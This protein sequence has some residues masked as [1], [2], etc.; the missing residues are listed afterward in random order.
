MARGAPG[1]SDLPAEV[2]R[3]AVA[4]CL[5]PIG[6]ARLRAA[7]IYWR[8]VAD[9]SALAAC[10][11]AIGLPA[12]L[13]PAAVKRWSEQDDD[14][15]GDGDE[16]GDPSED[17]PSPQGPSAGWSLLPGTRRCASTSASA[18]AR[19]AVGCYSWLRQRPASVR[20]PFAARDYRGSS[21]LSSRGAEACDGC[22]PHGLINVGADPRCPASVGPPTRCEPPMGTNCSSGEM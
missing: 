16:D 19:S 22:A 12:G 17:E 8:A 18:L 5:D 9:A 2:Q 20:A 6:L 13:V 15:D 11:D 4:C 14:N 3:S 21:R 10:A 7:N 1:L